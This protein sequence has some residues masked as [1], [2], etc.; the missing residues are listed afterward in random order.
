MAK[1]LPGKE[2]VKSGMR[3]VPKETVKSGVRGVP[4]LKLEKMLEGGAKNVPETLVHTPVKTKVVMNAA[5]GV[6]TVSKSQ[7]LNCAPVVISRA[8]TAGSTTDRTDR[9]QT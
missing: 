8:F 2:I 6:N 4:A 9:Y 5:K 7:N 1:D 3:A